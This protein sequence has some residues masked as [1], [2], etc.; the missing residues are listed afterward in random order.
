MSNPQR[1]AALWHYGDVVLAG[2][3]LAFAIGGLIGHYRLRPRYDRW[4][5][6]GDDRNGT[7]PDAAAISYAN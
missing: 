5:E 4:L 1:A 6:S 2:L 7:K 3:V